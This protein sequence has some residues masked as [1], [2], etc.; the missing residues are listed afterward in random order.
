MWHIYDIFTSAE[1]KKIRRKG[2]RSL[3][4]TIKKMCIASAHLDLLPLHCTIPAMHT[5]RSS[6]RR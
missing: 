4:E 1:K 6:G 2:R 5:S 3:I